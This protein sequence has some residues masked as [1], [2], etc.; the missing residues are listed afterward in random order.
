ML[1]TPVT[2]LEEK[3][4][5]ELSKAPAC[6]AKECHVYLVRHALSIF[7]KRLTKLGRYTN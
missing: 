3:T 4:D 2:L 7:Y 6:T 1:K 5:L